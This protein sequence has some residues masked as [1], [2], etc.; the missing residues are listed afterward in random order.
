MEALFFFFR[1]RGPGSNFQIY[2]VGV[3]VYSIVNY[4]EEE[5]QFGDLSENR[6]NSEQYLIQLS[7]FFFFFLWGRE[8]KRMGASN[9][10]LSL[11]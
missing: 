6:L 2:V 9:S 3:A 11:M 4:M 8:G 5:F 1:H 7:G 10:E